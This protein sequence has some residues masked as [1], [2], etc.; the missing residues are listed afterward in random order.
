M[1]APFP[2]HVTYP[3][4]YEDRCRRTLEAALS[5]VPAYATWQALDPGPSAPIMARYAALPALTKDDLRAHTARAFVHPGCDVDTAL[6]AGVVEFVATSG[7]TSE[8]V[9]NLWHQAWWDASERAAWQSNQLGARVVTGTHREALLTSALSVGVCSDDSDLSMDQR[10]AGRF[11]F[12]NEKS[13]PALW[14][15]RHYDRM[16]A[17]LCAFKPDVLEA[18]PSYLARFAQE[19]IAHPRPLFMPR[20]VVLTFEL[21][22]RLH[23]RAI[24][25][26]FSCPVVSSYGSTEAGYVFTECEH[27]CFH[28]NCAY[29]HVDVQPLLPEHGGPALARILVTTFDNPWCALIR[30]DVGDLV[31][32]RL[33]SPC[34]C[35]RTD[36][37]VLDA[38]EGRL[39]HV[40]F[41]TAGRAVTLR[42]AD[43][44]LARIPGLSAYLLR[45]TDR[46]AYHVRI[47]ADS[48]HAARAIAHSSAALH[49]LYG[50]DAEISVESV[51]D[52]APEASGKFFLT[53]AACDAS[54]QMLLDARY[55]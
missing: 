27:G 20:L 3:P 1:K 42:E 50:A 4:E 17:E 23:L 53:R 39:A 38:L 2:L 30:F 22:S 34:P 25:R 52:I 44:V 29:C 41:T 13:S 19:L 15:A 5:T 51:P 32:L 14:T 21:P 40:T 55:A 46:A 8:R 37:I 35:G 11:L 47:V 49:V 18:N 33:S 6:Q 7:T 9:V 43:A 10:C 16:C 48:R 36:G 45:Q 24:R 12:L 54:P 26:V 31:R 28:Q